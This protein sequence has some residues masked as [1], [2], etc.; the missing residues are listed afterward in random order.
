MHSRRYEFN[1]RVGSLESR[2]G[3]LESRVGSLDKPIIAI[4][5]VQALSVSDSTAPFNPWQML[6]PS[7]WSA[8]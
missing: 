2:V 5:G 3:S 8:L 1:I 6:W 4:V 7:S